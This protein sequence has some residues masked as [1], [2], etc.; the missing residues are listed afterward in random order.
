MDANDTDDLVYSDGKAYYYDKQLA[1]GDYQYYFQ[2]A[3]YLSAQVTTST[4]DLTVNNIPTLS[5]GTR[6]PTDPVYVDTTLYFNVTFTDIDGDLPDNIKWRE[7]A[8]V[9]QNES[10]TETDAGD[11]DT[12]DG[13]VYTY[14]TT[15]GHGVH[16]FDFYADDGNGSVSGQ[17][18]TVTIV[19]RAPSITNDPGESS[20]YR[21]TYW[22]YDFEA[23]DPDTDTLVWE[24]SSNAT[25]LNINSA[26]GLVYGTTSDPVAW[27]S[28]TVWANDSYGG[29]DSL[30]FG[31]NVTNRAPVINS[32][33]NTTQENNTFMSYNIQATDADS[34]VMTYE[35]N[36]NSTDL[37]I[38]NH[39]VNGTMTVVGWFDCHLWVNDSYGGSDYENWQLTV[40][41]PA[42]NSAPYFTSTPIYSVANNTFYSYDSNASDADGDTLWYNVTTNCTELS[43][44]H[45]L[46][47]VNGTPVGLGTYYVNITVWD[48]NVSG[49]NLSAHQNYT[50]TL[51]NTLPEFTSS[52]TLTGTVGVAY[53]YDADA[54]DANDDIL[55]YD[56]EY[57]NATWLFIDN[58]TGLVEG[59]PTTAGFFIVNISVFDGIG[60]DFQNY[61]LTT[62]EA[63]GAPGP[64]PGYI[65]EG[66]IET[67][68]FGMIIGMVVVM[69]Y[70]MMRRKKQTKGKGEDNKRRKSG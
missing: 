2:T 39:W 13:K 31:L 70:A 60:Y 19:N 46:G 34:D 56:L 24:M 54:T 23:T 43:I 30:Y 10:M 3:D 37:S 29:S 66:D 41:E 36:S 51:T 12:T 6:E 28:T 32:A 20:E 57:T 15:L 44:H 25:F 18:D 14:S 62:S 53:S 55:V 7:D 50:L 63:A 42:V 1:A 22:D 40:T 61:T 11:T 16:T 27:Y 52:P 48:T 58:D 65:T 35:F 5:G 33:G 47:Y 4:K 69:V 68:M 26:S 45:L 17:G 67:C 64:A 9:T 59:T 21:N 49:G 38:E 8:G